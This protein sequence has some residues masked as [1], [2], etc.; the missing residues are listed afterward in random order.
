MAV[1]NLNDYTPGLLRRGKPPSPLRSRSAGGIQGPTRPIP[2]CVVLAALR[3]AEGSRVGDPAGVQLRNAG[4]RLAA[5]YA[6]EDAATAMASRSCV[7]VN[8]L[9]TTTTPSGAPEM[10]AVSA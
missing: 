7:A 4:G 2:Y 1:C 3:R 8:G 5:L 6:P 10:A 9:E